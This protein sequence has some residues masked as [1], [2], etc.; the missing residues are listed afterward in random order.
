MEGHRNSQFSRISRAILVVDDDPLIVTL[1]T[2]FLEEAG[3]TVLGA[4]GSSEAL[5]ICTQ[6]QG[7]IDLLLTD[8]IMPLPAF[9]LASAANQ[10]P[11]LNGHDLAIRATRIRRGLRIILMSGNP[12]TELVDHGIKRG[13][14]PFVAKPF[15]PDHLISIVRHVLAQPAPILRV[16]TPAGVGHDIKWFG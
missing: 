2:A 9:Q 15:E 4:N 6:H 16:E 3:F 1:C 10:F 12:D 11:N 8:L 14:F 5:T 13:A 7:P